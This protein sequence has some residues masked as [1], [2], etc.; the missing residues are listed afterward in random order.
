M[1]YLGL[2]LGRHSVQA[3]LWRSNIGVPVEAHL[4]GLEVESGSWKPVLAQRILDG[5]G[6][7]SSDIW[8]RLHEVSLAA[9]S[10]LEHAAEAERVGEWLP[11][12]REL[13]AATVLPELVRIGNSDGG[14]K[15]RHRLCVASTAPVTDQLR[16]V[17]V[18]AAAPVLDLAPERVLDASPCALIGRRQERGGAMNGPVLHVHLGGET[19][20]AHLWDAV[21]GERSLTLHRLAWRRSRAASVGAIL[22]AVYRKVVGEWGFLWVDRGPDP[23]REEEIISKIRRHVTQSLAAER[24][25]WGLMWRYDVPMDYRLFAQWRKATGPAQFPADQVRAIIDAGGEALMTLVRTVLES[26]GVASGEVREVVA[27]GAG[28]DDLYLLPCLQREFGARCPASGKAEVLPALGAGAASYYMN[29]PESPLR[30]EIRDGMSIG[31]ELADGLFDPLIS[32]GG[33]GWNEMVRVYDNPTGLRELTLRAGVRR[34][35]AALPPLG[36]IPLP[37]AAVGPGG[38]M[39]RVWRD[40]DTWW[41]EARAR[42]GAG[43]GPVVLEMP[44]SKE[45]SEVGA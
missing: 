29:A 1:A 23:N 28:A 5:A 31:T 22:H 11:E 36:R 33:D 12:V 9:R 43:G 10:L 14:A 19:A 45:G 13:L 17:L 37:E 32:E 30:L 27:T 16:K 39:L 4:A 42:S 15:V 21:E 38:L 8:D 34:A 40:S 26:A 35:N 25:N 2:K 3:A 20:Q 7:W 24:A 6:V 44:K 18:E 41:A